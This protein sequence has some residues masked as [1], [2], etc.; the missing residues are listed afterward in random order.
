MLLSV[1]N[2]FSNAFN[3]SNQVL[4]EVSLNLSVLSKDN[5]LYL[6]HKSVMVKL[7]ILYL[8]K[9]SWKEFMDRNLKSI[10]LINFTATFI[11]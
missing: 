7:T 9:N 2:G 11:D 10:L 8:R 3:L 4:I 5:T 1:F 6:L